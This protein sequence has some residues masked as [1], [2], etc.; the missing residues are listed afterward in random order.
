MN[1]VLDAANIGWAFGEDHFNA[2]GI[3]RAMDFFAD[4]P[5][6]SVTSFLPAAF[7]KKK[8]T[9]EGKKGGNAMMETDDWTILNSLVL[10]KSLS[11]V[12]AG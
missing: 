3:T 4:V 11:L 6:I 2:E 5:F 1:V 8:P 10:N 12:P 9:G 7:V